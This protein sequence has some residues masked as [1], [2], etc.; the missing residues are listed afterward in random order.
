[1]SALIGDSILN[2]GSS[3][4]QRSGATETIS[5][6]LRPS[7]FMLPNVANP[8]EFCRTNFSAEKGKVIYDVLY[9]IYANSFA[10]REFVVVVSV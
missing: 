1:M 3:K 6:E 5:E 4:W 8:A 2:I 7:H 10:Y 9:D